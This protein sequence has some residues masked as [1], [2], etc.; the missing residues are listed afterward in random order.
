[1]SWE[2]GDIGVLVFIIQKQR[3]IARKV[4]LLQAK[5]LYPSVGDIQDEDA[6]GFQY[7]MNMFLRREEYPTSMLLS[8]V[9]RFNADS[10][11]GA[12]KAGSEQEETIRK[13]EQRFGDSVYYMFY[14]PPS[15]PLEVCYPLEAYR[16]LET[17]PSLGIRVIHGAAVHGLLDGWPVGRVPTIAEV[18]AIGDP[19]GGWRLE[20]WAAD[21]LLTCREGS[22]YESPDEPRIR[23][24]VERRTGPIGAAIAVS[25]EL[26]PGMTAS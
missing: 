26:P 24:L 21:L 17:Q 4:A 25:I 8:K 15:I 22:R 1:M 12:L 18:G 23:N 16:T 9:Y 10:S 7:G 3:I 6:V 13:F 5:R 14:N 20:E 19:A 11:Y 2:I